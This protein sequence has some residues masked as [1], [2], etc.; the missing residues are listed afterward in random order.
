MF[1]GYNDEHFCISC[2]VGNA[3]V[4]DIDAAAASTFFATDNKSFVPTFNCFIHNISKCWMSR[5]LIHLCIQASFFIDR[6]QLRW[7]GS[8]HG[9][10]RRGRGRWHRQRRSAVIELYVMYLCRRTMTI[11]YCVKTVWIID[12]CLVLWILYVLMYNFL[13]YDPFWRLPVRGGTQNKGYVKNNI[14]IG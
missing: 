7:W 10:I 4:D 3:S 11:Y 12:L 2:S 5:L 9:R 14:F 13:L 8:K 6:M 1:I